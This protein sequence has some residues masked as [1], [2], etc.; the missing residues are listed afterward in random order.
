V[1]KT[2]DISLP[3]N[4]DTLLYPGDDTLQI[5]PVSDFTGSALYAN[6][7]VLP[8]HL[9]TH[10]DAP[11]HFIPGGKSLGQLELKHFMGPAVVFDLTG[12]E[13]IEAIDLQHLDIPAAHHVFFKTDNSALLATG[14][15]STT[16]TCLTEAA[17]RYI[18]SKHPLS[19]GFDYYSIDAFE[20]A[21]FSAHTVFAQ[22]QLPVFVCLDLR[23]IQK[24]PYMFSGM[25]LPV[26]G[27]EACPVRAVLMEDM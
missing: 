1:Q 27:I 7:I 14:K 19:F 8:C 18:C 5:I 25:P 6:K 12:K 13:R 9:G 22:N 15:F 23:G 2:Y 4:K 3:L 16:Y 10:A 11:L 26:E 17:A 20:D 21:A 24:G